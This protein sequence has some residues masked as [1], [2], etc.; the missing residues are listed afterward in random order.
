DTAIASEKGYLREA[1]NLLF[2]ISLIV[3]LLA[4]AAGQLWKSEGG[5]LIVEGD[6]FANTLTQYDDFKS[7]SLFR[8]D[9]LD[10]FSFSL[11]SFSG[12]Y[13]RTGPQKGTPRD[14]A[15]HITYSD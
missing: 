12:S 1:G 5:K 8:A 13:E 4:F 10:P 7:G 9:D 6:G 11:D 3:L 15:A 2:H 14:Y